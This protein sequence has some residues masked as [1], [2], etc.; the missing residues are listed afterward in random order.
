MSE[1][2]LVQGEHGAKVH[3]DGEPVANDKEIAVGS[4][5]SVLTYSG[6]LSVPSLDPGISWHDFTVGEG[7]ILVDREITLIATQGSDPDDQ[8]AIIGSRVVDTDTVRLTLLSLEELAVEPFGTVVKI[9]AI[10]GVS[11]NE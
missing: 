4:G 2:T 7:L 6:I 9:T 3:C 1:Y 5:T 8:V 10:Y 11:I